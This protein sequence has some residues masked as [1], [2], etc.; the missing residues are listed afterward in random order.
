MRIDLLI[1]F[2]SVC[3]LRGGGHLEPP[4]VQTV[5][6]VDRVTTP[7]EAGAFKMR[8]EI[9]KLNQQKPASNGPLRLRI[10][11]ECCKFFFK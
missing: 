2:I 7:A 4:G 1:A 10:S 11:K 3:S 8:S 9:S 6:A 5:C